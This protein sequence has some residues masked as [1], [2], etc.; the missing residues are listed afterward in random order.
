MSAL[1]KVR[2]TN[3]EASVGKALDPN[4]AIGG[5]ARGRNSHEN[6]KFAA[7]NIA[8]APATKYKKTCCENSENLSCLLE[9]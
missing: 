1:S 9:R 2:F 5:Y 3:Y 8:F 7:G 6:V 4:K